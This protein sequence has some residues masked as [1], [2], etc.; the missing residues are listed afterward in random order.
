MMQFDFEQI[1][2]LYKLKYACR[3]SPITNLDAL[4][5][6]ERPALGE[7]EPYKYGTI[8]LYTCRE[9]NSN[10]SSN[11]KVFLCNGKFVGLWLWECVSILVALKL[12]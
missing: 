3:I 4:A 2:D 12:A 11:L 7:Y 6:L 10:R 9:L 1:G 8:L 5:N